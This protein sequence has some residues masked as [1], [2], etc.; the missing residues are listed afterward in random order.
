MKKNKFIFLALTVSFF[1][2]PLYVFGAEI[3]RPEITDRFLQE[4]KQRE[5]QSEKTGDSSEEKATENNKGASSEISP[6]NIFD[7]SE[8][9]KQMV[10]NLS[11]SRSQSKDESQSQSEEDELGER[12]ARAGVKF[13]ASDE[14]VTPGKI[15]P[16]TKK[17]IKDKVRGT[18]PKTGEASTYIVTLMGVLVLVVYGYITKKRIKGGDGC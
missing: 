12:R 9:S 5:M 7:V 13:V 18:L 14:D 6:A 11:G 17:E 1:V 3:I 10:G 16:P 4:E 15:I 2:Q 8:L